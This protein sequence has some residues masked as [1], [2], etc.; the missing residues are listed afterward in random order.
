MGF[1]GGVGHQI[2][3]YGGCSMVAERSENGL[4]S[5]RESPVNSDQP[6]EPSSAEVEGTCKD[7]VKLRIKSGASQRQMIRFLGELRQNDDLQLMQLKSSDQGDAQIR[8]RIKTS[9]PLR[10]VL[11]QMAC[12]AQVGALSPF[13]GADQE[14]FLEV[15]LAESRPPQP[16]YSSAGISE[17]ISDATTTTGEAGGSRVPAEHN[18][19]QGVS[20]HP[21]NRGQPAAASIDGA[22]QETVKLRVKAGT[23]WQMADFSQHL[24]RQAGVR[25]LP[26]V[27]NKKEAT[28]VWLGFQHG[29]CLEDVLL[30]IE[31]VSQVD[32][33][34]PCANSDDETVV[35]VQ[36]APAS[37]IV[38]SSP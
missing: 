13:Y 23:A 16:M 12:I 19:G 5:I 32:M 27:S 28:Y 9:L 38:Y 3:P 10:E 20:R 35:S 26:M 11:G 15:Q 24:R 30:G 14:A 17:A 34:G 6:E 36:L 25:L 18:E 29:L 2:Y 8:L 7:S 33:G 31:C 4:L 1:N 21:S 37:A 22:L